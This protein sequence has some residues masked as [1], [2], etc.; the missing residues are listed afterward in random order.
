MNNENEELKPLS[1]DDSESL[2]P[3]SIDLTEADQR[4]SVPLSKT[5]TN[6]IKNRDSNFVFFFGEKE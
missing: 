6:E 1:L 3:L 4:S 5:A 2:K